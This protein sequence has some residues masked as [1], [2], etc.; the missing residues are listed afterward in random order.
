[1]YREDGK[2]RRKGVEVLETERVEAPT[3]PESTAGLDRLVTAFLRSLVAAGYSAS[4][5]AA[6]RVDLRQFGEFLR[7]G[8]IDRVSDIRP[9]DVRAFV[10]GLAEGGA[11]GHPG[12]YARASIARKL[13]SV[14]R[15]LAFCVDEGVLPASPAVEIT[16]PKLPRHLPQVLTQEQA[17][18]LLEA[19]D[20]RDPLDIRDR[21]LLELLYSCG[22]RSR[23]ILDLDVQD[24]DP[25]RRE[26]RVR[27]KGRKVR[28]VPVGDK[29]AQATARYL[30]EARPSLLSGHASGERRLFVSRRGRPLSPSDVR[31]RLQT[32]LRQAAVQAGIS[33]HTLR[34]SFATHLLEGGA[35]LRSIQE[36]L[37]HASLRTTQIYTHVSA[38][39]LRRAYRLAHPR[40]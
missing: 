23:E 31:R 15:F 4:T 34:H 36:L 37:G 8:E 3:R 1:M 26:V 39:H 5:L 22:L 20:G 7:R 33:P 19:I 35:D 29:A 11:A 16:A 14:R 40:A 10:A 27:G 21:A 9:R 12:A 17:A 6:A 38:T 24:L 28:V 18:A 2:N 25:E 30:R 32:R 13:S